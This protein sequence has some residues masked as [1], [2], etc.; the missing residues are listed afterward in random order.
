MLWTTIECL[1]IKI[2]RLFHIVCFIDSY[3]AKISDFCF[4]FSLNYEDSNKY[5]AAA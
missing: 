5:K 4:I 1:A 2:H 3:Q